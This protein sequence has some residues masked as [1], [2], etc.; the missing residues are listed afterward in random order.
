VGIITDLWPPSGTDLTNK[1]VGGRATPQNGTTYTVRQTSKTIAIGGRDISQILIDGAN[2][3]LNAGTSK[4][5]VGQ[6]ITITYNSSASELW[7]SENRGAQVLRN[8][9]LFTHQR[10]PALSHRAGERATREF[11][12]WLARSD[13]SPACPYDRP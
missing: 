3:G 1:A 13:D 4:L 5:A 6:S 8:G 9:L 7:S 11:V 2:A 12:P 10:G